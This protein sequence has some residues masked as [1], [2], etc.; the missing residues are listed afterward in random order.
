MRFSD[1]RL[2]A[3]VMIAAPVSDIVEALQNDD[4]EKPLRPQ[5]GPLPVADQ[6]DE[7]QILGLRGEAPP[8]GP[9]VSLAP[10]AGAWQPEII[11]D[12]GVIGNPSTIPPDTAGAVNTD[13]AFAPHNNR[14]WIQDRM[15]STIADMTLDSFWN[16][17][18]EPLDTF[19]PK[20]L[21]DPLTQRF[22][23]VTCANAARP[24]SSIL[25][26]ASVNDDPNGDWVYGR[27]TVDP[28]S[29]GE[30]WLDYPS[31]GFTEDKI[32]VSLN[33]FSLAG[34]E[35]SGIA[36]FVI[37]KPAFLDPP[38]SFTFD[39]FVMDDQGGTHA[40]ASVLDPGVSDQYLLTTWTGD[41]QGKGYLALY[42]LTG[43]VGEGT[44]DLRRV[45]FLEVDATWAASPPGGVD[46]A[47][48]LGSARKINTG[49]NRMQTVVQRHDRLYAVHTVFLPETGPDRS[50]VQW[51]EIT[52]DDPPAVANHGFIEDP[53]GG[54]FYAYPSV[55]VNG[56]HD[57][58]I[59]MA[60][61]SDNIHASGAYAIQPAG[62]SFGAPTVF[63]PG[64]NTYELT[65]RGNRNRWGDYSATQVDPEDD[66]S[67]WTIQEYAGATVNT[68][69][70]KWARI[71]PA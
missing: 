64:E 2:G 49:D 18:G 59:G 39:Q 66:L 53:A 51:L 38:H 69:R 7:A 17:F 21:Y 16:V 63:A 40:P 67:F 20:V 25:V 45:G 70:T 22:L 28:E 52:L 34:N 13:A 10:E 42:R 11:F 4:V 50:A 23:F 15:G 60:A 58:L 31:F 37:D 68:W 9:E 5:T 57:V 12:S 27:I 61:F 56:Q 26:A 44:T 29:M 36:V 32:T 1:P 46:F 65:F 33:L 14:I 55:A 6:L 48:Q 41:W 30:V 47:P 43:Q 8:V 54:E 71:T 3:A 35:F 62:Q 19:D 24:D